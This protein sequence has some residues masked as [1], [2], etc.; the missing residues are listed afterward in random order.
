MTKANT[1][2]KKKTAKAEVVSSDAGRDARPV[3][4]VTGRRL[5][6]EPEEFVI[7]KPFAAAVEPEVMVR[8]LSCGQDN[9]A[10]EWQDNND[11]CPNCDWK[12]DD[13]GDRTDE[14]RERLSEAELLFEMIDGAND[15]DEYVIK[16]D[17][18]PNYFQD[19]KAN[20]TAL[21]KFC[22]YLRG[23]EVTLDFMETLRRSCICPCLS[24]GQEGRFLFTA[25]KVNGEDRGFKR[26]W[27]DSITKPLPEEKP[28]PTAS[29]G[30]LQPAAAPQKSVKEELKESVELVKELYTIMAPAR[31]Q[32]PPAPPLPPADPMEVVRSTF[33]LFKDLRGE[34]RDVFADAVPVGGE[35]NWVDSAATLVDKLGIGQLVTSVGTI[36]ANEVI[37]ARR[38][39]AAAGNGA[40]AAD[41]ARGSA[42]PPS[43]GSHSMS[44]SPTALPA[45]AS[46][47][48]GETAAPTA[49]AAPSA[50]ANADAGAQSISE[51]E[52]KVLQIVIAEIRAY[53][54]DEDQDRLEERVATAG[55]AMRTLPADQLAL[56]L[57]TP[58]AFLISHLAQLQPEWADIANMKDAGAFIG[59]LKET[60]L[61][62]PGEGSDE[63]EPGDVIHFPS[64]VEEGKSEP[65]SSAGEKEAD[66]ARKEEGTLHRDEN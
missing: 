9:A 64:A 6:G 52:M 36:I 34:M 13:S 10:A 3:E 58:N 63:T 7:E 55:G 22:R 20:T 62:G 47:V 18:L 11:A 28:A 32:N 60:L 44:P 59:A 48:A 53:E 23:N 45:I 14:Q 39:A 21:K 24:P 43:G 40:N 56:I 31:Q 33:G 25:S 4:T 19:G 61:A 2:E 41:A 17:H 15:E 35:R 5:R 30:A 50:V 8:C 37:R 42:S 27:D 46:A 26:R 12:A 51:S 29:V 66:D 57:A 49:Q 54:E 65:P 38:E 1:E 16:V